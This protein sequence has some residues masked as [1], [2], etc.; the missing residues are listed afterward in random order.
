MVETARVI[1]LSEAAPI[2]RERFRDTFWGRA[3]RHIARDKL[4]V[5]AVCL[6]ALITLST[7]LAPVI[8]TSV[9]KVD[10]DR[11][12]PAERLL[13]PGA[14]GHLLGTDDLGRDYLARL[15]YGGRISLAIGFFGATITLL[16][17]LSLG[18]ITGY[19]GGRIDDVMNW[20]ITTLDSI[21]GLYL[22]I[23]LSALF[24][25]G[26]EV[27]VFLLALTGWTGGTRL[28]RGQTIGLRHQDYIL[29][30]QAIG[31]P[32]WRIIFVHI[33]PNLLSITLIALAS[34]IGGLIVAESTLSFLGLGVQPPVPTWGNML[35]NA[36]LFFRSG[37][38]IAIIPG[39]VIFITV[40][41]FYII[42]DGLRDAFD[43]R[44]TS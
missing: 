7:I 27:L 14:P 28:I 40:L 26:P 43:P 23:L 21:P 19:Y 34:G 17:G 24:R 29:G 22:L 25:P 18:M 12:N 36:E 8:T 3:L 20:I 30:A 38:H 32:A 42:G 39:F 35:S 16:I 15:L 31:A 33:F 9:L 44:M 1:K 10:P 6:V 13:R 37:P 41:S 2:P 11:T 4:T 5:V